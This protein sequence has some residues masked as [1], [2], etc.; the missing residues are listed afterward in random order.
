MNDKNKKRR[1]SLLNIIEAAAAVVIIIL[2]VFFIGALKDRN[3]VSLSEPVTVEIPTGTGASAA[4]DILHDSGVIKHPFIFRLE[5]KINGY[6]SS[7]Q[8]GS[9]TVTD[10]MS[11][12]DILNEIVKTNRDTITVSIPEGYEARQIAQ[13]LADAG[14]VSYDDFMAALDPSLYNYRFL[15]D[16]P[17]DRPVKLEGYL[18]PTTYSIPRGYSAVE[19]VNMMLSVFDSV[20]TDEM[21]ARAEEVNITVDEAVIMASIVERETSSD[22][23]RAKVAGVFYN[24]INS[25]MNLQSCATVQYILGERK[26]V[27]SIAD[28]QIDSP[29]NTYKYPGLP[30]G[31]ISNPGEE[32]LK[33]ALYPEKTDAFYFCLS[34][35]G[36]HIFSKTYEE[37]LAAMNSNDLV[38]S[39]EQ[40]G[41]AQ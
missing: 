28:T 4:A 37:H 34:K 22:S 32:C 16:I 6:D 7:Y 12:D 25:G 19:I 10:G 17:A 8:P 27:L 35:S 21:Y 30:V 9:I 1:L 15:S 11:Y 13:T 41:E 3:G 29:Y 18:F 23:E 38:M 33:A 14:V 40:N 24:R 26:P 5:S 36:E 39:V 2:A 31:P 20:F